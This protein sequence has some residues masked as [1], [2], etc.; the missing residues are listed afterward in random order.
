MSNPKCVQKFYR[1]IWSWPENIKSTIGD[2][3]D[4]FQYFLPISFAVYAIAF[5][6]WNGLS[7]FV[8]FFIGCVATS[9][10][11]KYLFNNIRPCDWAKQTDHPE[12]SPNM[13]WD[14]S[15]KEGQSFCSGH[16]M[17]S[18]AGALPW[19]TVDVWAGV[20][21]VFLAS[22]VGFSRMVVQAHWLRDVLMSITFALIYFGL[23]YYWL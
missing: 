5:L 9:T 7:T 17:A 19:F 14:W 21:A 8:V 23:I 3:G 22:F 15:P 2:W 10:L 16:T 13:N 6:G 11:M 18:F 12:I 1:K 4:F 20:I